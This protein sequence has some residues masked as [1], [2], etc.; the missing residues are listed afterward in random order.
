MRHVQR[1]LREADRARRRILFFWFLLRVFLCVW[2]FFRKGL[3]MQLAR[4]LFDGGGDA[5][6]GAVHSIADHGVAAVADGMDNLPSR[7]GGELFHFARGAA[8]LRLGE[9][10]KIRLELS[11]F[12]K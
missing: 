9:H 1:E 7:E 6:T 8:G 12:F 2:G 5:R 3:R 10:K 11:D 4:E